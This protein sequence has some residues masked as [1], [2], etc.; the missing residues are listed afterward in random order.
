M[1]TFKWIDWF[2]IRRIWQF[3]KVAFPYIHLQIHV[4]LCLFCLTGKNRTMS[5]LFSRQHIQTKM[6]DVHLQ[7]LQIG[8]TK[9]YSE[10]WVFDI[11]GY[12]VAITWLIIVH[13][14]SGKK[15]CKKE[16]KLMF[17]CNQ[18]QFC[19]TIRILST[20]IFVDNEILIFS[21]IQLR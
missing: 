3:I 2:R 20:C 11:D 13:C 19:K 14:G 7:A 10:V 9:L 21:S 1:F 8:S 6:L 15:I 16:E 17:I 4:L 18:L 5:R 12:L